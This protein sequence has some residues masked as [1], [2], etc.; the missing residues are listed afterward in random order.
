MKKYSNQ[1]LREILE[2]VI[3]KNLKHKHYDRTVKLAKHYKRI[4]TGEDQGELVLSYKPRETDAQKEQRCSITNT[5]TPYVANKVVSVY[6]KVPRADNIVDNIY[7]MN[8]DREE[9]VQEI[10]D[11][12]V[13]FNNGESLKDYL[14]EAFE[15]YTFHD[16][17]AWLI[18]EFRKDVTGKDK[19]YTYPVEVTSEQA[20]YFEYW[21][22]ELQYL[23]VNQ[24]CDVFE[25]D[26]MKGPKGRP[27][28]PVTKALDKYYQGIVRKGDKFLLY[29]ADYAIEYTEIAVTGKAIM[30]D[31]IYEDAEIVVLKVNGNDKRFAARFF[32]TM[33]KVCPCKRFG[34]IRDPM[35]A[36]QTFIS[37][38]WSADYI[39]RDLINTKSEFD[40]AKAL[41]GFLQKIQYAPM[42]DYET[43]FEQNKDRCMGGKLNLSG[44]NCPSCGGLGLKIHKTT[45]DIILVKWPDGKEEHIPLKQAVHYVEV[46]KHMIQMW[47]EQVDKLEKAVSF[48]IFNT[49]LFDRTE[50]MITATEKRANLE[51]ANDV[52]NDYASQLAAF[53]QFVTLL[54]AIHTQN[55]SDD[56]IIEYKFP[57]DF[58]LASINDL[59]IDRGLAL[60]S[61]AP[62]MQIQAID[63]QIISKQSQDNPDNIE[64]FKVREKFRPF[65]EKSKEEKMFILAELAPDD[66]K[67]VL[68]INFEE[69]MD[70]IEE[71][72]SESPFY[73][74]EYKT[75]R[76][77]VSK[78]I[79]EFTPEP[80][81]PVTPAVQ[82]FRQNGVPDAVTE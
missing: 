1:E 61:G 34:Y 73:L 45:Q 47:D 66:P 24:G 72:H 18:T 5:R 62:Y 32:D 30:E 7:Y 22:N 8:E 19:P 81:A 29:A 28:D 40:L 58:K 56:L 11:R 20:I 36:R 38:M 26:A 3:S 43:G 63:M 17:N 82:A 25:K 49:N 16:P 50:V 71:E 48:A 64:W 79:D 53:Y 14:T 39:F 65:R 46:P 77:I 74:M 23:I 60:N 37:P 15:H 13:N 75:Q 35:T 70:R 69:I 21:H 41:H 80:V 76:D 6:K 9:A 51:S 67:K 10:R 31:A 42:C 44:K 78:M 59:L 54:T 33:S 27:D 2:K 68:Y 57:S 12:F 52:I 55:D 4:M